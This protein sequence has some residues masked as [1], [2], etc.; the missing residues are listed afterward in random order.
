M[1]YESKNEESQPLIGQQPIQPQQPNIQYVYV[2]QQQQQQPQ[3]Q[4]PQ[5][6]PQYVYVPQQQPQGYYQPQPQYIIAGGEPACGKKCSFFDNPTHATIFFILG[7]FVPLLW[8]CG[9]AFGRSPNKS[10]RVLG[11]IS[12]IMYALTMIATIITL[13]CLL[14][15]SYFDNWYN[16]NNCYYNDYN[17]N[18][19]SSDNNNYSS[20]NNNNNNYSSENYN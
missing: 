17:N 5:Y 8:I 19:Y 15:A 4:P 2:P 1:A 12:T 14:Q 16:Y 9:P 6:Q 3:Q 10:A 7:F 13:A 11:I 20:D 18:N